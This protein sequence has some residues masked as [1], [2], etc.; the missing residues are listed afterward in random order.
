MLWGLLFWKQF[1]DNGFWSAGNYCN[2]PSQTGFFSSCGSWLSPYGTFFLQWY[3]SSLLGHGRRVGSAASEVL[4]GSGVQLSIKAPSAHWWYNEPSHPVS[5]KKLLSTTHL[6]TSL[7]FQDE[8]LR[9]LKELPGQ[10]GIAGVFWN[11]TPRQGT[12]AARVAPREILLRT[13]R[14]FFG[15]ILQGFQNSWDSPSSSLPAVRSCDRFLLDSLPD[16]CQHFPPSNVTSRVS[17]LLS[18][19]RQ[20]LKIL[21]VLCRRN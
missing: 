18:T 3:S 20:R 9:S 19:L 2:W 11:G 1:T 12:F 16:F 4:R 10:M 7:G 21:T 5:P 17:T 15:K 6:G 14:F 13:M 8:S